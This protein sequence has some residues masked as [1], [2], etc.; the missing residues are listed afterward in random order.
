[1]KKLFTLL[2]LATCF[3]AVSWSCSDDYDDSEL[4]KEIE[5][6]KEELAQIKS[7]ISSL[8]TII[9]AV[10]T[11]KF[12]TNIVKTDDGYT[13]TFSGGE[14]ITVNNGKNGTNA[15]V[16]GIDL[17]EGV[18][19]WTLGGKGNWITDGSGNKIP[20]AGKDGASPKLDVDAEGYWTVGGT[21]ITGTDGKPVKATGADGDSFFKNVQETDDEVIFTLN[22]DTEI[23]I[24]KAKEIN[25]VIEKTALVLEYGTSKA[26]AV[27]QHGVLN[28]SIAKP[29]GWRATLDGDVLTITAPVAENTYAEREGKV[30][31]VAVGATA[32]VIAV[33]EVT[34]T[35][36]ILED[37]GAG[38]SNWEEW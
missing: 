21:R 2:A 27:T 1:M 36:A 30:S 15:P 10:D 34:A 8:Q 38:D 37:S 32:T 13:I 3:A 6:I 35:D 33:V 20:V 12:I 9:N 19:Y 28:Y 31:V 25:F 7:Q 14:T 24:P 29:D 26:L 18:Y 16:V 11:D 5:K 23:R 22:D 17:F 4:R